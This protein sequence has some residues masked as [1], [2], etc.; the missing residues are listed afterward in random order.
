L[1]GGNRFS[2]HY[3]IFQVLAPGGFI[4][5]LAHVSVTDHQ[6]GI[7]STDQ[8]A[9]LGIPVPDDTPGFS[10]GLDSWKMSGYQ[11]Q[12][13]LKASTGEYAFNLE[14]EAQKEPVFHDRTG[15]VDFGEAGKSYYY[16][17]TRMSVSGVITVG[18]REEAVTGQVWFDHQWGDF[19]VRA[20]G[21]DWFALQ[22][23]DGSDLMLTLLRDEEDRLIRS[24]ATYVALDG[25]STHLAGNEF[26]VVSTDSWT[27]PI[28]RATYPMRWKVR[29]PD[30]DFNVDLTP[31]LVASEFDGTATTYNYYWEG[32]VTVTGSHEG[33]GFVELAGYA[34]VDIPPQMSGTDSPSR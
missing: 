25:R 23:D 14:L 1:P 30:R 22:L 9:R 29:I 31:V 12:D 7:Y 28:S 11:G 15:L 24:Y 33:H 26:E 34:Q 32:E 8:K 27:S 18:N 3:A 20:L 16:S 2:F 6:E 13:S 17:R 10:F 21:W 19:E 5:N 4:A